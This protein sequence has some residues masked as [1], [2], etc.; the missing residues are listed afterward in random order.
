MKR[1]VIFDLDGTLTNTIPD[2]EDNVNKT[3]R[4]FGII[5]KNLAKEK[6]Y[7]ND[8]QFKSQGKWP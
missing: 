7:D 3:M 5:V 1:L 2:I 4:K 8:N 6:I